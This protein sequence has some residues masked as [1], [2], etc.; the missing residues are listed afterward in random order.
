MKSNITYT[1]RL[2]LQCCYV[3][4]NAVTASCRSMITLNS[5][6]FSSPGFHAS[7]GAAQT[8]PS[9]GDD[10]GVGG[11]STCAVQV[12]KLSD[13][14]CQIRLDF[15]EF[16]LERPTVGNCD[17]E[18]LIVTGQN[19]NNVVPPLCGLNTGQHMY[20]DV[21]MSPGPVNLYVETNGTRNSRWNIKISQIK[22]DSPTRAPSNCLQYYTGTSG[23]FSSFDYAE[24]Q[25]I[26]PR[27]GYLNNLDYTVCFRKEAGYCSI[28]YSVPGMDVPFSIQNVGADN[29]PTTNETEA[30]LGVTECTMDY[31][32]LGGVRYCGTKLNPSTEIPNPVINAPVTVLFAARLPSF[33]RAGSTYRRATRTAIHA[34]EAEKLQ[35]AICDGAVSEAKNENAS[36]T[37]LT[38]EPLRSLGKKRATAFRPGRGVDISSRHCISQLRRAGS[39]RSIGNALH[40]R[41]G[42]QRPAASRD[43]QK[44]SDCDLPA[45][46][47]EFVNLRFVDTS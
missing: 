6:Y 13:H 2:K 28:T 40:W 31:L 1:E 43:C 32:L 35:G 15:D 41:I 29:A 30:G 9:D 45:E 8:P 33:H 16:D 24:A 5:T 36:A 20:I 10:S 19:A 17:G 23:N 37:G 18:K 12:F 4:V 22:C 25:E 14:I 46:S 38:S 3:C 21:D 34:E 47:A 39:G 7:P 11:Q 26:P 42:K 44:V 27:R